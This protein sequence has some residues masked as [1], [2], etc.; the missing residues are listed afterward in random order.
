MK[1]YLNIYE[2]AI[3]K[4]SRYIT[5]NR[6]LLKIWVKS[7]KNTC[8]GVNFTKIWA[9]HRCFTLIKPEHLFSRVALS[10]CCCISG[11]WLKDGQKVSLLQGPLGSR[12]TC[13]QSLMQKFNIKNLDTQK[14]KLVFCVTKNIFFFDTGLHHRFYVTIKIYHHDITF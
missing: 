6:K 9:L 2:S 7:L 12:S 4:S 14:T 3:V 1:R 13:C 8:Y 5:Y 11:R 10:N